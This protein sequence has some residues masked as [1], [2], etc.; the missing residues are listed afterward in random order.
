[1]ANNRKDSEERICL[2]AVKSD[3]PQTAANLLSLPY[4][5]GVAGSTQHRPLINYLQIVVRRRRLG[6]GVLGGQGRSGHDAPA[7]DRARATGRTLGKPTLPQFLESEP[8]GKTSTYK[9]TRQYRASEAEVPTQGGPNM[10]DE[11]R[12]DRSTPLEDLYAEYTVYDM[13]Y[14]KIGK[15]DDLFVDENDNPE[16]VGVKMGFLGTRSTLIP[17]DIVRVNDRRRLVEVAADKDTVKNGPTFSDDREITPEFERQVLN[18]YRVEGRQG[19]ANSEGYDAYYPEATKDERVGLRPGERVGDTRAANERA[20]AATGD[21]G[22]GRPAS[23]RREATAGTA[24]EGA[25]ERSSE[26]TI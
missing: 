18:Y 2:L 4:K 5:E 15:I 14:E 7:G 12:R 21:T 25:G 19:S 17:V 23:P 9:R 13:H 6:G 16:Y 22:R 8:T 3:Q 11:E 1:M 20:D 10:V 26:R 24:G